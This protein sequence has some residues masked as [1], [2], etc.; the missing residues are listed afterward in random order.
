MESHTREQNS[1]R[2]TAGSNPLTI[3]KEKK[4]RKRIYLSTAVAIS[5]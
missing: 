1:D 5:V 4:C 2:N 3:N